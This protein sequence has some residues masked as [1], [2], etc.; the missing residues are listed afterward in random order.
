MIDTGIGIAAEDLPRIFEEF[1]QIE[2]PLQA[3][4]KG[5]GLGL[6]LTRKLA[7]LL[8]GSVSVQSEPGVGSTFSVAIPRVYRPPTE[9]ES[10]TPDSESSD[11]R[12]RAACGQVPSF[13]LWT[14][15]R[16]I[17]TL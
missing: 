12:V 11:A 9:V 14:I 17:V 8:G 3:W 5:T 2:N 1:S 15:R 16:R 7:E 13:S 4:S 6:P 10:A